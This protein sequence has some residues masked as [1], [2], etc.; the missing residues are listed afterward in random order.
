MYNSGYVKQIRQIELHIIVNYGPSF[1]EF[2]TLK[3]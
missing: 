1:I 2:S 3:S